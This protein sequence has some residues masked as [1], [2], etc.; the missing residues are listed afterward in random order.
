[1]FVPQIDRMSLFFFKFLFSF[2][3]PAPVE[4]QTKDVNFKQSLQQS[5]L[6]EPLTS[7]LE[8]TQEDTCTTYFLVQ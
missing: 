1:M 5:N 2:I 7:D 6:K 4:V 8:E 3:T